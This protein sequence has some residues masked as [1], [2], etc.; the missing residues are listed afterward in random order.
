MNELCYSLAGEKLLN[1]IPECA[2]GIQTLYSKMTCIPSYESSV[3]LFWS[4][5]TIYLDFMT[6]LTHTMDV[7][8][9]TPWPTSAQAM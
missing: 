9:L 3:P 7:G 1:L 8:A 6:I 4:Q 5:E 2:K